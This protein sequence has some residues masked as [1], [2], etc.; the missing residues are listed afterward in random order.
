VG[1]DLGALGRRQQAPRVDADGTVASGDWV[2]SVTDGVL[3]VA[4]TGDA[5]TWWQ[6]VAVAG[7][8]HLDTTGGAADVSALSPPGS[9]SAQGRRP[10]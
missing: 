9:V 2:A 3:D 4:G 5:D 8:R 10:R 7:W 6:A 1:A